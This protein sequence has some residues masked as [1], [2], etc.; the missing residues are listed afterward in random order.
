MTEETNTTT[1]TTQTEQPQEQA[2]TQ[3]NLLDTTAQTTEDTS[4]QRPEWLPEK[5]K[6][7]EDMA[8]SYT[9][10]EKKVSDAPKVPEQYDYT[11]VKDMGLE[12]NEDQTKEANE[13][14]RNYGL[15]QEQVKGMMALYSDSIQQL[16]ADMGP[17]VDL[18]KETNHLKQTWG[19]DYEAKLGQ[20]R[21]FAKNIN[22]DVLNTPLAS[23]AD[24]LQILHDA[25]QYRNGPNPIADAGVSPLATRETLLNKAR[26]MR[27]DKRFTLPA[28][29][30]VG[31][32]WRQQIYQLYQ[33]MDRLPK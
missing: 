30:S 2:Q 29:D 26:E 9:E 25:M 32:E 33:K 1:T 15:T 19:T 20:V 17:Q 14:F 3:E 27:E 22:K 7:P 12:M 24:G 11:F 31:D 18:A 10:L 13:V 21:T 4:T 28:G 6:S 16:Q 5:F 8:K 23:T